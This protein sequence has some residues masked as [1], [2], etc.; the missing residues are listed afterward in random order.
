MRRRA[1]IAI[2]RMTGRL[3]ACEAILH[4]LQHPAPACPAR[5]TEDQEG[6]PGEPSQPA[7]ARQRKRGKAPA[8]RRRLPELEVDAGD[9]RPLDAQLTDEQ[10]APAGNDRGRNVERHVAHAHGREA[11]CS[12][13]DAAAADRKDARVHDNVRVN[14]LR[15][16]QQATDG[17]RGRGG[18][19]RRQSS[20]PWR[21]NL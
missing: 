18:A 10:A 21:L 17:V 8:A 13:A 14:V 7:R 3:H 12:S 6:T 1:R 5:D 15:S 9:H 19:G 4:A 2:L 11:Q 16:V 20:G